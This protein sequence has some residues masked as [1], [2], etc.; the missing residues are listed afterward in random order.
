MNTKQFLLTLEYMYEAVVT[1]SQGLHYHILLVISV[2][3]L[4]QFL[5]RCV[6]CIDPNDYSR[7]PTKNHC[8]IF[9][10]SQSSY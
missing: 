9:L 5:A 8:L 3:T 7:F 4:V 2:A 10:S 6:L 1:G